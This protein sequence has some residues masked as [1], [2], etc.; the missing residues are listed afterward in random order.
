MNPPYFFEDY[1]LK[2]AFASMHHEHFFDVTEG[3]TRM[4]DVFHFRAPLGFLGRIA[5]RLFLTA[6]MKKLLIQRN[7]FL[8]QHLE[9]G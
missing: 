9:K 1:M 8:K 6:Y 5:E 3:G 7:A 2:G 4:R